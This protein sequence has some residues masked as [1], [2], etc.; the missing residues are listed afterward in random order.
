MRRLPELTR[1]YPAARRPAAKPEPAA[2]LAR[3]LGRP[4]EPTPAQVLGLQRAIG[5][6]ATGRLLRTADSRDGDRRDRGAR[7]TRDP[8]R[9]ITGAF[10]S[11]WAGRKLLAHYM[12]G[13]GRKA[14]ILDDPE[15]TAY[16][17]ASERLRRQ[18][19][20]VVLA[21]AAELILRRKPGDLPVYRSYH[22]EFEN[23]E[24]M[25]GYQFLHGTNKTVGDFHVV[26]WGTV[27]P[28]ASAG[29]A[30]V[31]THHPHVPDVLP[32]Q[33]GWRVDFDLTFVW[34]DIIDPNGKYISDTIKN[35]IAELAT[36][37]DAESYTISIGWRDRCTA[38]IPEKGAD[39]LGGG[40]PAH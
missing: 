20:E 25:V 35:G 22:A 17:T 5:N 3:L 27:T 7:G 19:E 33:R 15:W 21:L 2:E 31:P 38:V 40:Y 8:V 28:L 23:G 26:G 30:V 36:L 14:D 9:A 4:T 10:D 18:N 11:D 1:L 24:G 39:Q 34:N 32:H 6:A 12:L 16:M 29:A 13:E 37:G